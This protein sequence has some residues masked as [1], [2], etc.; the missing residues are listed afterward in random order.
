MLKGNGNFLK[1]KRISRRIKV[2][3]VFL[4]FNFNIVSKKYTFEKRIAKKGIATTKR[5]LKCIFFC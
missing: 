1:K 2:F 4:V 5:H 3:V